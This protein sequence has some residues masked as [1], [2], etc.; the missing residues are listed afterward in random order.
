VTASIIPEAPPDVFRTFSLREN[1]AFRRAVE[2]A[3]FDGLIA[4]A[5]KQRF[6]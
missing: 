6:N 1:T 4:V 3:V 2:P 5:P